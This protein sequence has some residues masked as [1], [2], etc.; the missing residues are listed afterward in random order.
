MVSTSRGVNLVTNV[1]NFCVVRETGAVEK[2]YH[3]VGR[4]ILQSVILEAANGV[5]LGDKHDGTDESG[6]KV[7]VHG[8]D[9]LCDPSDGCASK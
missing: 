1:P 5:W 8:R 2:Y 6:T 4:G 9:I 7:P 3:E